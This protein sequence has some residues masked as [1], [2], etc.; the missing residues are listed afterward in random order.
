MT[1]VVLKGASQIDEVNNQGD[2]NGKYKKDVIS[3]IFEYILTQYSWKQWL[4]KCGKLAEQAT[5]KELVQIHNM[6]ALQPLDA[7]KLMEE[8]KKGVIASLL[9]WQRKEMEQ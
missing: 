4:R 1:T 8:E 2:S 9:F 6:D 7:N 5:E 3:T